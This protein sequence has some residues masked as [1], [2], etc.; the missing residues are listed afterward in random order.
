MR[1]R[2]AYVCPELASKYHFSWQRESGPASADVKIAREVAGIMPDAA[3]AP[4]GRADE[5]A[6]SP[7]PRGNRGAARNGEGMWRSESLAMS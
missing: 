1:G 4:R 2:W 3:A 5:M 6:W 7:N